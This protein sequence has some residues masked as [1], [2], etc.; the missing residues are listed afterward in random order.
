PKRT[1]YLFDPE[2]HAKDW[3]DAIDW[4]REQHFSSLN[5]S[6]DKLSTK[7]IGQ[8]SDNQVG[9]NIQNSSSVTK[10]FSGR[11]KSPSSGVE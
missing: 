10:L 6:K 5:K 2:R 1:Y 8:N 3:C 4:A 11:T 9:G 7:T